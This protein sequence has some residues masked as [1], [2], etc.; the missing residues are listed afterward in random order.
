MGSEAV[1]VA[2]LPDSNLQSGGDVCAKE[3]SALEHLHQYVSGIFWWNLRE[4]KQSRCL[5][6]TVCWVKHLVRCDL[7]NASQAYS[8]LLDVMFFT[9]CVTA[10]TVGYVL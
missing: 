5:H 4:I 2:L 8:L 7:F 6:P 10:V 1:A 3:A 9:L